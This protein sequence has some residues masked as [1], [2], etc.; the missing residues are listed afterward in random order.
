MPDKICQWISR[1]IRSTFL[2]KALSLSTFVQPSPGLQA[3]RQRNIMHIPF[4]ILAFCLFYTIHGVLREREFELYCLILAI[5]IVT[6]YIIVNFGLNVHPLKSI[7]LV[8]KAIIINR[9]L[10]SCVSSLF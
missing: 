9:A 10:I 7:K 2:S 4:L 6:V 8:S 1:L 3:K 5:L